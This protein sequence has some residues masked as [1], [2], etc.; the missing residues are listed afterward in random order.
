MDRSS[1]SAVAERGLEELRVQ[2]EEHQG[3][4]DSSRTVEPVWFTCATR[5]VSGVSSTCRNGAC[6]CSW[7]STEWDPI[8]CAGACGS[9]RAARCEFVGSQNYC[10][11]GQQYPNCS[12]N[13]S[14]VGGNRTNVTPT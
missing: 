1:G 13:T 11:R 12:D 14:T 6:A 10:G 2:D 3:G 4:F 7:R 5:P 8:H 9:A